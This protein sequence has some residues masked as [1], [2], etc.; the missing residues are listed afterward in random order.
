MQFVISAWAALV[1]LQA[2]QRTAYILFLVHGGVK[3]WLGLATAG[4]A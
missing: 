1:E 4:C 2:W 3:M